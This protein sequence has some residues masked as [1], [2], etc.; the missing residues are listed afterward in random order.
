MITI[1]LPARVL[2]RGSYVLKLN[3]ISP[4]RKPEEVAVYIFRVAND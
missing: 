2:K 4:N 1:E 3:G